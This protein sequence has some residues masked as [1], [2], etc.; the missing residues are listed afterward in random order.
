VRPAGDPA[1][2]TKPV[3]Q[4]LHEVAPS[5][6]IADTRPVFEIM[7]SKARQERMLAWLS[8]A[9]GALAL[10]LASVGLYGVI[11]YRAELRTQEFG[12]R[13]AL[14]A[15]P[16]QVRRLLLREVAGLLAI[17]LAIGGVATLALGKWMGTLLFGLTP[18]DPMM[19]LFAAGLLSA[20]AAL[21]GYLPARRAARMDPMT[22]LRQE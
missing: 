14:G 8:G 6:K 20:V 16:E 1:S 17:G 18:R 2:F 12:I 5:L 19:L 15:R 13:L 21:A 7:E 10:V 9:F 11:A 22:A 4:I 3:I